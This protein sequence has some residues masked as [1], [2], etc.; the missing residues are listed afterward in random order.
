[1]ATKSKTAQTNPVAL[2][3][4]TG[5]ASLRS[6]T[7]RFSILVCLYASQQEQTSD[8]ILAFV[9]AFH[10]GATRSKVKARLWTLT[11]QGLI[12]KRVNFDSHFKLNLPIVEKRF[13]GLNKSKLPKE[14]NS[15]IFKLHYLMHQ[16]KS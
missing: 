5:P 2:S 9:Q 8:E 3:A 1:M 10:P 15:R 11:V 12:L 13:Y 6:C 14:Q 4:D 16:L 7:M